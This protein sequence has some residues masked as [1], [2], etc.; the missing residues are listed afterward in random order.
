MRDFPLVRLSYLWAVH[1]I[2]YC[3]LHLGTD[4]LIYSVWLLLSHKLLSS[5]SSAYYKAS[6]FYVDCEAY[7]EIITF[8]CVPVC[9][10]LF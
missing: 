10:F 7:L 5:G 8:G 9:L 2:I 4:P 1:I 3:S 6:S